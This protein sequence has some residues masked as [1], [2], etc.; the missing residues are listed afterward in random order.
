MRRGPRRVSG[1]RPT[2]TGMAVSGDDVRRAALALPEV[3]ERPSHGT[4]AFFVG[5]KLVA[6]FSERPAT[7]VVP[8]ADLE[9][10]EALLAADPAVFSTTAHY[11]GHA[12]VL[13]S[14]EAVDAAELSE[15]LADAWRAR[16]PRSLVRA[17][18][19]D[20]GGR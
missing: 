17:R 2:L 8:V 3:V 7:L 14:L 16:A 5:R 11:D 12:Y 15:L 19:G 6:R 20:A 18:G 9:E 10:K 4:A 1:V 13:V